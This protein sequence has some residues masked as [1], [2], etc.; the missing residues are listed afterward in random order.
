MKKVFLLDTNL[1]SKPLYENL[2]KNNFEVFTIG[3]NIED[4]LACSEFN[5]IQ[6]DYSDYDKVISLIKKMEISYVLPGCNDASYLSCSH[7]NEKLDLKM[8]IESVYNTILL[9]EKDKFRAFCLRNDIYS[10]KLY[11]NINDID[12]DQIIIKPIDSFSGKGITILDKNFKREDLNNAIRIAEQ[13]SNSKKYVIEEFIEGQLYSFSCFLENE[14]IKNHFIVE[15][16][17]KVNRFSVDNSYLVN[18]LNEKISQSIISQ[19][20]RIS[21]LIKLKDGL[22]HLQFILK[23][24]TPYFIEITRRC[25]GD[26]YSLLIEKSSAFPYSSSYVNYL[27]KLD[28]CQFI[29][30]SYNP[31]L[32]VSNFLD[33]A[34]R[35]NY[36]FKPNEE[37]FYFKRNN[38]IVKKN[39]ERI[40]V[41]F[42]K[43]NSKEFLLKNIHNYEN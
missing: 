28:S 4:I 6:L 35:V 10:P 25:P 23:G 30:E 17:S 3:N 29:K 22:L 40:S 31:Y 14:K 9:N 2:K 1:S 37:V 43:F 13:N 12:S 24:D 19:I 8:N 36:T 27:M 20:E 16:H 5:F 21:N 32:R 39:K 38:Y 33:K 34:E 7:I 42:L 15:E 11:V 26:L 18:D 41:S